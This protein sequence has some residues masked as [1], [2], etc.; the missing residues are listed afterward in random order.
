MDVV[1][2]FKEKA[3]MT[4]KCNILCKNCPLY[5]NFLGRDVFCTGLENDYP[6]KAV[7]IVEKWSKEHPQ[8]TYLSDF[9]EKYPNVLLNEKGFPQQICPYSLGYEKD[10]CFNRNTGRVNYC[11]QTC[12]D[13]WNTPMED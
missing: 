7:E 1:R 11:G 6:E 4:Q 2:Y 13:C 8:K 3:R 9:L 5:C 12:F 10:P